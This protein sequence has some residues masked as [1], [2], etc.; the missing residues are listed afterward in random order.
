VIVRVDAQSRSTGRAL[1]PLPGDAERTWVTPG[2]RPGPGAGGRPPRR[3]AAAAPAPPAPPAAARWRAGRC[4]WRTSRGRHVAERPHQEGSPGH[5]EQAAGGGGQHVPAAPATA[6]RPA[7][8][9]HQRDD[10]GTEGDGG[11]QPAVGLRADR[12]EGAQQRTD[13][14]QD[15]RERPDDQRCGHGAWRGRLLG[16]AWQPERHGD[17]DD[18]ASGAC[19][20]WSSTSPASWTSRA[21]WT[22]LLRPSLVRMLETWVFTVGTLR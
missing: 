12:A 3:G 10:D 20:S 17:E 13:P 15:Q 19:Q 18:S 8:H 16:R 1:Q 6:S 9:E 11:R 21:T 7:P 4:W 2:P 14:E 22:R 5:P